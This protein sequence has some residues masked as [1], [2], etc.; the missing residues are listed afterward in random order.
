ME[1]E[2]VK[3]IKK[4]LEYC[5]ILTNKDLPME[6]R[7]KACNDCPYDGIERCTPLLVKN[8]LTLINELE[9]ENIQRQNLINEF[10]KENETLYDDIHKKGMKG[11]KKENKELKDRIATLEEDK[12]KWQRKAIYYYEKAKSYGIECIIDT[13]IDEKLKECLGK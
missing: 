12:K 6:T 11:L 8:S 1:N 9:S 2:K 7:D 5:S 10:S 3:E 4:V 13:D